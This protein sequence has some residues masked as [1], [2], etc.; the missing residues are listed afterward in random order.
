MLIAKTVVG[1]LQTN[2]YLYGCPE[3]RRAVVIDPGDEGDLIRRELK[4]HG[5]ELVKVILTHGHSDHI[6]ALDDVL[7]GFEAPVMIHAEDAAMLGDPERNLSVYMGRSFAFRKPVLE[8]QDGQEIAVGNRKL[9]VLHTP[10]HTPGSI[11][12]AGNGLVLSG[13]TLF[14]GGVGRTDLPGGSMKALV[15][16]I[17]EKLLVLPDETLV[18]PGH[19]PET[20]IGAERKDNPYLEAEW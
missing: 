4:R 12:L 19:G 13:D 15:D 14:S 17:R 9:K 11:C 3:T 5:Y 18:Y 6:M 8:L 2:C 16:S 1:P 10:G 7:A 20:T